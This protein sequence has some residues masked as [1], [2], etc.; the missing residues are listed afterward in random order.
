MPN[1]EQANKYLQWSYHLNKKLETFKNQNREWASAFIFSLTI[2]SITPNRGRASKYL[3]WC[4]HLNK[5]LETVI[6]YHL[7]KKNK[8]Q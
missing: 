7:N 5:N 4:Y 8:K 2:F 3:Q 6:K 1:R